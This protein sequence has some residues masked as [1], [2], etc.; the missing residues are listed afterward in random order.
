[1]MN[2]KIFAKLFLSFCLVFSLA[3]GCSNKGG[4]SG[5]GEKMIVYAGKTTPTIITKE[6]SIKVFLFAWGGG[7]SAASPQAS[8]QK[9]K[10]STVRFLSNVLSKKDTVTVKNPALGN[11]A[12]QTQV[13]ET[14]NGSVSGSVTYRGTINDDGTGVLTI[15]YINYNDG[16]DTCDG[17]ATLTINSYDMSRDVSTNED[18]SIS[19]LT[20]TGPA[21]SVSLSGVIH[22]ENDVD[23]KTTR[24]VYN[25]DGRDELLG[26]TFKLENYRVTQNFDNW[27][28]PRTC[29][30][31]TTGRVYIESEGYV[32]IEQAG[33]FIYNYYGRFNEDIPDA[34]G[35]W[36]VRGA[37]GSSEKISPIS[38]SQFQ[39][40]VDTD[41]DSIYEQD[42]SYLWSDLVGIVYRFATSFGTTGYDE[43]YSVQATADGGY[44]TCGY[45][46]TGPS[47]GIDMYLVK[48]NSVGEVEWEKKFGGTNDDFGRS[49]VQTSGGDY[50]VA[51]Y[52]YP[53]TSTG[54]EDIYVVKTDA[55]GN[56][57]WQKTYGSVY[58]DWAYSMQATK[59]GGAIIA[60]AYAYGWKDMY[61]LKIS[62]GGTLEWETKF[63]GNYDQVAYSVASTADGGY[64]MAGFTMDV[65]TGRDDMY[66]LKTNSTGSVMWTSTFGKA[67]DDYAYSIKE[68]S[69]SGYIVAG[70]STNA[71]YLGKLDT[72]GK[73]VWEKTLNMGVA[74]SVVETIDGFIIAGEGSGGIHLLK[75]DRDGVQLWE[76]TFNGTQVYSLAN[77][78]DGG[79]VMVGYTWSSTVSSSHKDVYLVKTDTNGNISGAY[80][81]RPLALLSI[82]VNPLNTTIVKGT[83][84]QFSATGNYSDGIPRDLTKKAVWTSSDTNTAIVSS[85]GLVTALDVGGTTISATLGGISGTSHLTVNAVVPLFITLN[86]GSLGLPLSR[87]QQFTA[88]LTYSDNTSAD[89]T[90]SASWAS[91]NALAASVGNGVDPKGLVSTIGLGRTII[92][93]ADPVSSLT[94]SAVVTV[95]SQ[96]GGAM[97]GTALSLAPVASVFAGSSAVFGSQNGI[98]TGASFGSPKGVTSDGP[99]LYV[100][101]NNTIRKIVIATGEVTTLAGSAGVGGFINGTGSAARFSAP[102]GI[103]TDGA[104]LYVTD[105]SNNAIR[106]VVIATGEV[107]T[108]AGGPSI[109]QFYLPNDITTDGTNL[110]VAD[111][112]NYAIRKIE[113]ATGVLSTFA[114]QLGTSGS[115]DGTGTAA[116]FSRLTGITTDGSSLFVADWGNFAIRKIEIA[117]GAVTTFA[118]SAG[119]MGSVDGTG[120]SARFNLPYSIT[121]D[122]VYLY[123]VD[124]Y[125]NSTRKIEIS[126]ALVST[127]KPTDGAGNYPLFEELQGI[128]TDGNR[129]FLL[130]RS[131][132]VVHTIK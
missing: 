62:A 31:S 22:T 93:A 90:A 60:G 86:P 43:G 51:G 114:G 4:S 14:F 84:R 80:A 118:G 44:I 78:L 83:T 91:S 76:K 92:T 57:I 126:T 72:E 33:A 9:A 109:F 12:L 132:Y 85:A 82:T 129:L 94:G 32:D 67:F 17:T 29:S 97:Q 105:M 121:S 61:L 47:K 48:T 42:N 55:L 66:V 24:D 7:G 95:G 45:T 127:I 71:G 74:R 131:R 104:N 50:I 64:V 103:T 13:D 10:K 89:I 52:S 100:T 125:N 6:N 117:T 88:R 20:F 79:F 15:T 130:D 8:A 120:T 46:N 23:G 58:S 87:T 69:D 40:E 75:T 56:L 49:V 30:E 96:M 21:S 54:A 107:T 115:S 16:D 11:Y 77:G 34:G 37:M 119:S 128:S 2:S 99:N 124:E 123:I 111:T 81:V 110:Y 39:I 38:I 3:V 106:K 116:R 35:A 18:L 122:G 112:Q 65:A 70:V 108:I 27:F 59:D 98:G 53:P 19:R 68:T 102:A 101:D 113:I 73:V 41:G 1:M 26:E 5:P 36:I 28:S 25:V 63:G